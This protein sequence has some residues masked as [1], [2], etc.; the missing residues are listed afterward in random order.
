MV[1][2]FTRC[3]PATYEIVSFSA[4]LR[5]CTM[6]LPLAQ[7]RSQKGSRHAWKNATCCLPTS[8]SGMLH[9]RSPATEVSSTQRK[10]ELRIAEFRRFSFTRMS[11]GSD[12]KIGV[13]PIVA[14]TQLI[15]RSLQHQRAIATHLGLRSD[16]KHRHSDP[17]GR[18]FVGGQDV[19]T[20]YSLG[21]GNSV[22]NRQPG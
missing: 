11:D 4:V 6:V 16:F 17:S 3:L 19:R 8:S 22:S 10:G 21:A 14:S 9:L 2:R 18:Y 13:E 5:K 1:H 12:N 20:W 15:L 7:G